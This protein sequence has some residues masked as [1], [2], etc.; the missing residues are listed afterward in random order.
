MKKILKIIIIVLLVI[1]IVFQFKDYK[2]I[3][4]GIIDG[5]IDS[6]NV[7]EYISLGEYNGKAKHG[8]IV[9]EKVSKDLDNKI[10]YINVEEE[11]Q[12]VEIENVIKGLEILRKDKVDIIN[13]SIAFVYPNDKLEEE[14]KKCIKEGIIIVTAIDNLDVES[15]P[16]CLENVIAVAS[17]NSTLN[18]KNIVKVNKEDCNSYRAA[19]VTNYIVKNKLVDSKVDKIV[20][21]LNK[22]FSN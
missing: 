9:L 20:E 11:S 16:A 3:R 21:S 7:E 18:Y 19:Y 14:I 5:K 15:Y 4:V 10:Y 2:D 12:N 22:E 1:G 17:K 6:S 8:N 13:L